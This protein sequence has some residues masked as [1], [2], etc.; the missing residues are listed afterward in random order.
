MIRFCARAAAR[1]AGQLQ[2]KRSLFNV[3]EVKNVSLPNGIPGL[4]TAEGLNKAWT[5]VQSHAVEQLNGAI[6]RNKALS[7]V[8]G[9][10]SLRDL[11][12]F[13]KTSPEFDVDISYYAGQVYSNEF[14]VSSLLSEA[15]GPQDQ[16]GRV[17]YSQTRATPID[18]NNT[19]QHNSLLKHIE[20][21]KPEETA[22]LMH[23]QTLDKLVL[24]SFESEVSFR[25]LFLTQAEAIFSG[26]Y[27]WLV[28]HKGVKQLFLMNTYGWG[29]PPIFSSRDLQSF[30]SQAAGGSA[31]TSQPPTEDYVVPLLSV[32]V[33]QHAYLHDYGVL[34]KRK[35]LENVWNSIDWRVVTQR[36]NETQRG[37]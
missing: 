2:F 20:S 30:A 11:L 19:V 6:S 35:Y 28:Y 4:Y 26:G 1:S 33:W 24:N 32:S 25:E 9:A 16:V 31:V 29:V 37:A 8:G 21:N 15:K 18:I 7:E 3:A 27:T 14:A 5:S 17:N 36:F 10:L 23:Q 34:G 22:G 13:S 12:L